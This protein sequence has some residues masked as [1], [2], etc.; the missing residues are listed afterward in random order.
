MYAT[1]ARG[2]DTTL[3][4][5]YIETQSQRTESG[6]ERPLNGLLLHRRFTRVDAFGARAPLALV[7]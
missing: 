3:Y 4:I 2:G 1:G 7:H 6:R 5:L